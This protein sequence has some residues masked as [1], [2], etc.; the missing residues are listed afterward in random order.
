[1]SITYNHKQTV[2]QLNLIF[3]KC[4]NSKM[5]FRSD[6]KLE[7]AI[8]KVASLLNINRIQSAL[9]AVIFMFNLDDIEISTERVLTFFNLKVPDF[10]TIKSDLEKLIQTGLIKYKRE[11]N[12]KN[13]YN[14][15]FSINQKVMDAIFNNKNI[16]DALIE[17]DMSFVQFSGWIKRIIRNRSVRDFSMYELSEKV[18]DIERRNP[19]LL[20]IK[21]LKELKIDEVERMILYYL[22]ESLTDNE[23]TINL[24]LLI[25][26]LFGIDNY[27]SISSQFLQNEQNLQL[28]GLVKVISNGNIEDATISLTEKA[29]DFLLADSIILYRNTPKT[30][31]TI[32][33]HQSIVEK[34]LFFNEKQKNE[35]EFFKES[36]REQNL[37]KLIS[38]LKQA[39]IEK[40][41][42]ALFEGVPGGG[43]TE[44]ARQIAKTLQY[45]L[46]ILD[47]TKM[48]SAYFSESQKLVRDSFISFRETASSNE[49]PMVLLINEAD[50]LLHNRLQ[51]EKNESSEQTQ[52]E[53]QSILLEEFEKGGNII[54]LTTNLINNIDS[55][56]YRRFLFKIKFDYPDKSTMKKIYKSK[57]DWLNEDQLEE[58]SH[59]QLSGGEIDNIT[60]KVL[61]H[62][63]FHSEKPS[64]FELIDFCLKE[65]VEKRKLPKMGF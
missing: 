45:D 37:E 28:K 36:I 39:S 56:F 23:P 42:I 48:K 22:I 31:H 49:R 30:N 14:S 21:Q 19:N 29:K 63:V 20:Q 55:A 24:R 26:E 58:L 9:F 61:M 35:I 41:V 44:V 13:T 12:S 62:E 46:F 60:V 54:I 53:I 32:L 52:N 59:I 65:R 38:K 34:E 1:M 43:K 15:T 17:P 11:N 25:M 64:T 10:F 8:N 50:G 33:R 2:E 40:S 47:F 57:L 27:I 6:K 18:E 16:L 4:K 5:E 3:E 7:E 51:G